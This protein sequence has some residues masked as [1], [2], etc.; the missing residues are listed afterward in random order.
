M[1]D[2]LAAVTDMV[3]ELAAHA[4]VL[5]AAFEQLREVKTPV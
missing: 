1:T 5:R 4:P 2:R 3:P